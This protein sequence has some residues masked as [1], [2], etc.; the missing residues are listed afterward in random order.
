[1]AASYCSPSYSKPGA[2]RT[3]FY[4][5]FEQGAELFGPKRDAPFSSLAL[6]KLR[7]FL[8]SGPVASRALAI[9]FR[10]GRRRRR[11]GWHRVARRL[12]NLTWQEQLNRRPATQGRGRTPARAARCLPSHGYGAH[13]EIP[14]I[15]PW[16]CAHPQS[17]YVLG[18]REHPPHSQPRW[19]VHQAASRSIS[20]SRSAAIAHMMPVA[21][22]SSMLITG[23][24]AKGNSGTYRSSH[25]FP[26]RLCRQQQCT[27]VQSIEP[28]PQ[29]GSRDFHRRPTLHPAG[30]HVAQLGPSGTDPLRSPNS[31]RRTTTSNPLDY[32]QRFESPGQIGRSTLDHARTSLM[33]L[34]RPLHWD[35]PVLLK[36]PNE[37]RTPSRPPASQLPTSTRTPVTPAAL[38]HQGEQFSDGACARDPHDFT[39]VYHGA[40]T[41]AQAHAAL[42][43][44][45]TSSTS[46]PTMR[47]RTVLAFSQPPKIPIL[48]SK[49]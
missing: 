31:L 40:R 25:H 48:A 14:E 7:R 44:L 12:P 17:V 10:L 20:T 8:A 22:G 13:P 11:A 18:G 19:M 23:G 28:V 45:T 46:M 15:P 21:A 24:P 42:S 35:A 29:S 38:P 4:L 30:R 27:S 34:D 5:G 47:L 26:S 33:T 36:T 16:A 39:T 9:A 37:A 32:R 6:H 1:M 2:E 3:K 43:P 49:D 41:A